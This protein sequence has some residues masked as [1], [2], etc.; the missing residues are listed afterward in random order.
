M[1]PTPIIL[2]ALIL[3]ITAAIYLLTNSTT[4]IPQQN[5]P[6]IKILDGD[7]FILENQTIRLLCINT[8]EK[9]EDGYQE[10]SDFLESKLINAKNITLTGNKTD[11]YGRS[12]RWVYLDN[13]LLN[14]EILYSG[15]G[16]LYEFPE[17]DCSLL[18]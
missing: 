9:G 11:M 7:T 15:F 10:A 2:L 12:L 5:Q 13:I 16:V 1:K 17:E 6:E 8:P 4:T 3:L 14:Q 18:Q